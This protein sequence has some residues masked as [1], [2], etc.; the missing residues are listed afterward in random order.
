MNRTTMLALALL[1]VGALG[2]LT[3]GPAAAQEVLDCEDFASQAEAQAAYRADPT[4]PAD[5]DADEDG[6]ACELFDF[7]DEATDFDPVTA[8]GGTTA[9]TDTTTTTTTIPTTMASTGVGSVLTGSSSGGQ[10]GL[11]GLTAIGAAAV[12]GFLAL[13]SLR[14]AQG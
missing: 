10:A 6:L 5:N 3:V 7:E 12:C 9:A 2:G 11:L 1:A 4:D 14:L 8:A 13:R